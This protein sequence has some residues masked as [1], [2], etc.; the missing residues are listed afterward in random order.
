VLVLLTTGWLLLARA[1]S[2]L[3]RPLSAKASPPPSAD[4]YLA[5]FNGDVEY[6]AIYNNR[7]GAAEALKQADVLFV[8]HSRMQYA[9]RDRAVLHQFFPRAIQAILF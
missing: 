4:W 3:F 6:F 9:F 2:E 7:D 5:C 1:I 8:G